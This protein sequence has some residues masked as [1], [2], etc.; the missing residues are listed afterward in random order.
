MTDEEF[1]VLDELYF[2]QPF[3]HLVEELSMNADRLRAVLAALLKK[4]WIKCFYNMSDEVFE[5]E[6]D[7]ENQFEHYFYLAT[8]QGLL[9]HN[10]R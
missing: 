9:A 8:K 5:R 7:F 6:L 3:S 4:G 2:V 1:D 10:G